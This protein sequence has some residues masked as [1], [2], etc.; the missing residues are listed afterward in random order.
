M[1]GNR[2]ASWKSVDTSKKMKVEEI[3]MIFQPSHRYLSG[4]G[5]IR[6]ECV[7]LKL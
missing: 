1:L 6:V 5:Y 7:I 2:E 4:V 3:N